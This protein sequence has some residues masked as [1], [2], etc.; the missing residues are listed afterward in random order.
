MKT[1]LLTVLLPILKRRA[2]AVLNGVLDRLANSNDDRDRWA[3]DILEIRGDLKE[4]LGIFVTLVQS[5]AVVVNREGVISTAHLKSSADRSLE[6]LAKLASKIAKENVPVAEI[7][8]EDA[9]VENNR[10]ADI[11]EALRSLGDG[12]LGSPVPDDPRENPVEAEERKIEEIDKAHIGLLARH[13]LDQPERRPEG[14]GWSGD[15]NTAPSI[16]GNS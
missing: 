11:I 1:L 8:T 13:P 12:N 9:E 4:A 7:L 3:N 15:W 16:G 5:G 14:L 10:L 2:P 6:K